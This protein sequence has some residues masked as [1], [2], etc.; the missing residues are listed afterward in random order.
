[1]DNLDQ[2]QAITCVPRYGMASAGAHHGYGKD[3]KFTHKCEVLETI[4]HSTQVTYI[5]TWALFKIMQ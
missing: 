1:M 4:Q 3:M 2:Q 5:I